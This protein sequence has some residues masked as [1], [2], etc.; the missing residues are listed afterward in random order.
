MCGRVCQ[1]LG[2]VQLF[3]APSTIAHLAPLS[4]EFSRQECWSGLLFPSPGYLPDP[5][6]KPGYPALQADS[7]PSELSGKPKMGGN[8]PYLRD[9]KHRF[10]ILMASVDSLGFGHK[11]PDAISAI[12]YLDHRK[13]STH[14][15]DE[16]HNENMGNLEIH[17]EVNV[18]DSFSPFGWG[19]TN[20]HEEEL[21][22]QISQDKTNG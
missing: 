21:P 7:L 15:L 16:L 2:C 10:Q 14:V 17:Q 20:R 12:Q 19:N 1:S 3:V 4:I 9:N 22:H 8:Y 5:G 11:P 6:F 18:C 13:D